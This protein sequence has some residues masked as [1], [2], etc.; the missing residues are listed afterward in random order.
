MKSEHVWNNKAHTDFTN[1][2]DI[3]ES[4]GTVRYR[5]RFSKKD[6][7]NETKMPEGAY[8]YFRSF[9]EFKAAKFNLVLPEEPDCN[10]A[11]ME[12]VLK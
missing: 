7:L 9:N 10:E 12:S 5:R 3:C 1:V 11:I 8:E 2:L 6:I 4:C